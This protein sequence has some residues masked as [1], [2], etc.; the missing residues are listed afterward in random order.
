MF[1]GQAC[2]GSSRF[3]VERPLYDE[4]VKRFSFVAGKV[5]MGDL[6]DPNTVI[7][8]IISQRHGDRVRSHLADAVAKGATI[9]AG[10]EWRATAA[11]RRC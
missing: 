2:I 1:A 11:N 6:R 7:A 8:P 4:F 10:G 5:G 9:A 3:Y